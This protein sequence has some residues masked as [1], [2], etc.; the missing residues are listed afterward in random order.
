MHGAHQMCQSLYREVGLYCLSDAGSEGT[1]VKEVIPLFVKDRSLAMSTG[2]PLI[3]IS[4][5]RLGSS[6]G[7]MCD[8]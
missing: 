1:T 5:T 7:G 6:G 3:V 8:T 4:I 2:R